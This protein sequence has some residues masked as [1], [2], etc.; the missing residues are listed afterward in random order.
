MKQQ[1]I[2][3]QRLGY[4]TAL[5]LLLS[6][7]LFLSGPLAGR[8]PSGIFNWITNTDTSFIGYAFL[9]AGALCLALFAWFQRRTDPADQPVSQRTA[10]ILAVILLC[11]AIP[12]KL[13]HLADV[14]YGAHN[15]E[16]VKG[17]QVLGFFQGD[18]FRPFFLANKEFLFFYML[19][20]FIWFGGPTIGSL[21][22][23]PF[24][25]GIATVFFTWLL[26]RRLWGTA[27]AWAGSGF[28]AV[29]LW[30]GQSCHICERLNA[31]PMFVSATLYAHIA[32]VQ[33]RRWTPWI[34]TGVLLAGGMWTF[35]TFRLIPFAVVSFS[36]WSLIKG[37]LHL[38][39]DSLKIL[40]M[41][42]IFAILVSAPLGF[43]LQDTYRVFYT[44][45]EH[46]F[47]IART[48]EQILQF[49]HQLLISFNVD[50][51]E[52]MSFTQFNAPVIWWPLSA[53]L[54]AGLIIVLIRFPKNSSVF[55][56]LWL[57]TALL[58][59]IISEPAV[60][61]LTAV[62]PLVFGLIGLGI[63]SFIH[64]LCPF[65][66]RWKMIPYFLCATLIVVNGVRDFSVFREKIAPVWRIAWE[67]Y[68][69]VRAGIDNFDRFEIHMDW[70]EEEAELPYRFLTYPETGN[71]NAYIPEPPQFSVPFRFTPE[72]D[73]MYLFRN[74]PENITV[75]PVL[76]ETYPKG[77]LSLHQTEEYPRGYY[78]FTM[79]R[80][81]LQD[82]RGIIATLTSSTDE[83]ESMTIPVIPPLFL[84]TMSL[85]GETLIKESGMFSH[86]DFVRMNGVLLIEKT[87][88]QD[89]FLRYPGEA[90]F[91]LDNRQAIPDD[92]TAGGAV[93]REFLTAGP[94]D[95]SIGLSLLPDSKST[96]LNIELLWQDTGQGHGS[97]SRP[98]WIPIP[99]ER[100]LKPPL[101][102]SMPK[103]FMT[104][105]ATFQYTLQKVINYPHPGGGRSYDLARLQQLPNGT[106]IGNCW[107]YQRMVILD[108]EGRML[109]DWDANL[110]SDPHWMLRFDFDIGED[111]HVYLTGDTRNRLLVASSSGEFL[112]QINLPA[113]PTMIEIDSDNTALLMCPGDLYRISLEDGSI[114]NTIG[115]I[116]D[117]PDAFKWPIAITTDSSQNIYVADRAFNRIQIYKPDGSYSKSIPVPGP[118]DDNFGMTIDDEGNILVPHFLIDYICV[119]TPDGQILTGQPAN[120]CDPLDSRQ[121]P[122]PRYVSL[123]DENSMWITNTESLYQF[124]RS[125]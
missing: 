56:L 54:V 7:Q 53:F 35:P 95:V 117:K 92:V 111:G 40:L 32:A 29:G 77:V 21:R 15:D 121:V 30:P 100:W 101:P 94:H 5:I 12:I 24:L 114:L 96:D 10:V 43:S 51:V 41:L 70:I 85:S 23:L 13:Y 62:Q 91:I 83:S 18:S 71:L 75:I 81:D 16:I 67:D 103:P 97:D 65:A 58:P 86:S 6:G 89:F 33:S 36:L 50:A 119:L 122:H 120:Q 105:P 3:L 68:W 48:P 98:D 118:L 22:S 20:P 113:T 42:L 57:L 106:F 37:D 25:C 39:A 108:H 63:V 52:D 17:M 28:L 74:I 26:L 1:G 104:R 80:K 93:F 82:R 109:L 69:I 99:E 123:P 125:P 19:T 55:S 8:K 76:K 88:R 61:R 66:T 112:R 11:L 124:S 73:F 115:S 72:K 45:H 2:F 107:H 78:S 59:A 34:T 38:K 87:G 14:P 79:T 84:T 44:R 47:K 9:L 116:G 110:Q 31:A 90:E 49:I 102:D 46:D 4:L 60:R 27:V 64:A